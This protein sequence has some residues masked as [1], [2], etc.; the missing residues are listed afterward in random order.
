MTRTLKRKTAGSTPKSR[1]KPSRKPAHEANGKV[2]TLLPRAK[3][4]PED[5]WDLSSLFTDDA[6]WEAA[7]ADWS[8]RI[9][10][11]A[12]FKGHLADTPKCWLPA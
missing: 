4:K 5:T 8:G 6:A 2:K 3:V 1:N 12:P 11:F 7:F 9:P 10:G